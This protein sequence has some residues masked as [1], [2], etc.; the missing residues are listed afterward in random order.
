MFNKWKAFTKKQKANQIFKYLLVILGTLVLAFGGAAFLV[1]TNINSGGLSGIAIVIKILAPVTPEQEIYVYNISIIALSVI[2]WLLGLIFIGKDFAFKSLLSSIIYPLGTALFT[3]VPG[4]KDFTNSIYTIFCQGTEVLTT[5]DL[6]LLGA[7][8]GTFVGFG[9][10]ATFLAGGSSGGVDVLSILLEKYAHVKESIGV[11]LVDGCIIATGIIISLVTKDTSLLKASMSGI[12]TAIISAII[13][14][15]MFI[16]VQHSYQADIISDKWED[17]SKYVQDVLGR[18]ATII[19]VSGGYKS[20]ERIILRVVF[21]ATQYRQLRQ[22][23]AEIDPKAFVTYTKTNATF[24]E[25]F[26]N[27]RVK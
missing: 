22:Y 25:G 2:F 11:L 27:H 21:D 20:D 23:I 9:V 18:G 5:G 6:V 3:L 13:I 12:V 1:P 26:K 19:R 8:G 16:S 15:L 24:G 4:V 10:S 17:I 14:E 7:F